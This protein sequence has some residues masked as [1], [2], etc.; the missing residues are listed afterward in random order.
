MA[1]TPS[2]STLPNA[3]SATISSGPCVVEPGQPAKPVTFGLRGTCLV[4]TTFS[5]GAVV[6]PAIGAAILMARPPDNYPRE[7]KDGG[8][9]FARNYG[10][11]A[12]RH[13]AGGIAKFAVAAIDREDPRYYASTST[14]FPNRL[15]HA[16]LFTLVDKTQSG[17]N[18]LA[19]SN[20]AGASAAGFIGMTYL[21]SRSYYHA[22]LTTPAY[23]LAPG[24]SDAVHGYQHV[25]I[26]LSSFAGQ[27]LIAEFY[28][29]LAKVARKLH[30]PVPKP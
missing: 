21:P 2:S 20:L 5:L 4:H 25:A 13:A 24:Y 29:E 9:A 3:P 18:T 15:T 19:F 11:R 27:N 16:I 14:K 10:D 30:L 23:S 17:H 26:E 8:D 22:T 28:P 7:W 6:S 12:A 1:Q